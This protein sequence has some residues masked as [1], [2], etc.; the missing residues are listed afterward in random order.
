MKKIIGFLLLILLSGLI[1][2]Q[3]NANDTQA[4]I[5]NSLLIQQLI[6]QQNAQQQ[7]NNVQEEKK[8]SKR[9][10]S[11]E[12]LLDLGYKRFKFDEDAEDNIVIQN[13]K[14]DEYEVD[15]YAV[16]KRN[17][18]GYYGSVLVKGKSGYKGNPLDDDL[19]SYR[20]IYMKVLNDEDAFI[21]NLGEKHDDQYFEIQ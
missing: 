1:F 19:D 11:E 6:N 2:A 17:S 21:K 14:S 10:S 12:D 18:L 7:Q 9:P 13:N 5:V 4:A 20:C 3:S 16:N 15:I 8:K